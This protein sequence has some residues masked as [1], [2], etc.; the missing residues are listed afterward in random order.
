MKRVIYIAFV[1][2]ALLPSCNSTFFYSTLNTEN[3]YVEKVDNGDFLLE[4]DSLWIAYCFKGESAPIQITVFNKLDKP[5]YIDWQRSALIINKVAY[6]YS[7][8]NASFSGKSQTFTNSYSTYPGQTSSYSEGGFD[9]SMNMPQNTTFIPPKTMIS[10]IPL[11]LDLNFDNI[12]KKSFKKGYMGNKNN[13]A[14]GIKRI[15]FDES[16]SPLQ[17]SSYLTI[18]ASP[19]KPMIFEQSFYMSNLI[20][21]SSITPNNLPT[22]MVDRG[23]FFYLEKPAN[24][25]ALDIILG[26]T[27][28]A[29]AIAIEI[30]VDSDRY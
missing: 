7:G 2:I 10:H 11:K 14:I 4:T 3:K 19:D 12:N 8:N 26:T 25:T 30:A 5:L 29:G 9:G 13:D 16:N 24:T 15:D 6:S 22:E 17:F 27:I 21:T 23:D 18:Y 20:K 1:L 28:V